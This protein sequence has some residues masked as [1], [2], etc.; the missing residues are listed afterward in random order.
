MMNQQSKIKNG[1]VAAAMLAGG[2]GC[3]FLGIMTSLSEG[4]HPV[5]NALN[6]YNPVGALSGKTLVAIV[7][8]L[9]S[10]AILASKWREQEVDFGK[11]YKVTLILVALGLLG[12]FPL[13]FG[14]L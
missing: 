12:T 6:W 8:W 9:I 2:I 13:F 1:L 3:L 10:W 14:L 5:E 11:V 4:I 7:L